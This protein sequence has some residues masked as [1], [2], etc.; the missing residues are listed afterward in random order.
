MHLR[1]PFILNGVCVQWQGWIDLKSLEGAGCIVF[2][3]ESAQ[4]EESIMIDQVNFYN[5][6]FVD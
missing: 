6:C 5:K 2:D 4:K 1:A 3:A